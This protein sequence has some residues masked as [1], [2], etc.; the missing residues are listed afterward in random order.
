M[1]NKRFETY[2]ENRKDLFIPF[3]VS[4]DPSPETTVDLAL[5]LEKAGANA[6]EL[7]IPYSDPLADGPVIQAASAR[8]LAHNMS[9]E[10][11]MKLVSKM[12]EEGLKIP[13]IIF[14]YYNLL[15]QLGKENFFALAQEN[16]IDGLLVPDMPFEESEELRVS[17]EQHNIA[18]I[19]LVAPTTSEARLTRIAENAQGFL[20][21]VSSLGVTGE[22]QEFHPSVYQFLEKVNAVSPVPVAVGF[23]ISNSSQVEALKDLCGG[24]IVGSAIVRK[25]EE[26]KDFLLD[27]SKKE[28]ALK[29]IYDDVSAIIAPYSKIKS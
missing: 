27:Q 22:R 19:S 11:S 8:A 18:Y 29:S 25:I 24:V 4:G 14:T 7:G 2:V 13:V 9:L 6:L 21:C 17:C 12:R 28:Q 3:I 5:T 26:Q 20:Y 23:G 1:G 16:E 10:R 15:L